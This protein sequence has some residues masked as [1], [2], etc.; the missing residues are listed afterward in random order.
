MGSKSRKGEEMEK[1]RSATYASSATS[2]GGENS[3]GNQRYQWRHRAA[4][5][6]TFQ[7][8][9]QSDLTPAT[10]TTLAAGVTESRPHS[11]SKNMNRKNWHRRGKQ[12][13]RGMLRIEKLLESDGEEAAAEDSVKDKTAKK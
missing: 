2:T 10:P 3:R 5:R 12:V 11:D 8:P 9:T 6:M 13:N 4:S 1:K 7:V